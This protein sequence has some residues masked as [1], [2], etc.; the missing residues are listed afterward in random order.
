MRLKG[1]VAIVTG[2]SSGIG[3]GIC[4]EMA[5]EGAKVV[6]ADLSEA[7]KIGKHHDTE[8][9]LPTAKVIAE[10]GGEALFVETD[11]AAEQS[12]QH[13]IDACIEHFGALDILVNNAGIHIPGTSQELAVADWDKVIAINLR[14]PFLSSKFAVPHLLRS[15]A[16]RIIHIASVHAFAGG[17]GPVYPPAKAALVNLTRDTAVELAPHNI[18]VNAICPGYIE[19]PIQDYLTQ[20]DIDASRARTPLPRLGLP[21]DIGR[22]AVFFASDDAEWITGTALPVDGGWL[23]PIM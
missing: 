14:G 15:R 3:R 22:A 16:G 1:R 10:M 9:Q 17:G 23:A 2:G 4:L 20:E 18:T 5:R 8:A 11:M 12:V 6:V 13:L 7:P 19:T 21:K